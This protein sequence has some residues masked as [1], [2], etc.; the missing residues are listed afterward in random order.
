M[1]LLRNL[2]AGNVI[3]DLRKASAIV[4]NSCSILEKN[5][6]SDKGIFHYYLSKRF[7]SNAES[8]LVL[9]VCVAF[10]WRRKRVNVEYV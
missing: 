2:T 10:L 9:R 5:K 4:N 1:Q 3:V 8:I 7:A 6:C